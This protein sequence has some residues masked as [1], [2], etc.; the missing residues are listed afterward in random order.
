MSQPKVRFPGSGVFF[1]ELKTRVAA[2]L[3][4]S[5]KG[6][7]GTAEMHWKTAII[8]MWLGASYLGLLLWAHT[9]PQIVALAASLGLAMAGIGF[10]IQHD[11]NHGGYSG[12]S[13]VNRVMALTLDMVGGSSYVWHWKHNVIH[14]TY[15]NIPQV[16]ADT[17][18][19]FFARLT[20]SHV[21]RGFHRYQH[22]YVWGLYALLPF[23][24]VFVDDFV[25]LATG[26]IGTQHFPK[27]SRWGM[28]GILA[29]KVFYVSW[30]LVLPLYLHPVAGVA[31]AYVVAALI[32]GLTLAI[33]FQVAH[34]QAD[35]EFPLPN[36]EGAM[37][38]DWATHQVATTVDFARDSRVL[39][40][41]LGGLNFQVEH[42]LFPRVCH[43]HYPAI[44]RIVEATCHD[45]GIRY[46]TH[47]TFGQ[48]LLAHARWLREMGSAPVLATTAP[49][50]A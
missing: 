20:P 2:H 40:W 28:A 21:R 7:H 24:W 49:A 8:L 42:H 34:C 46:R 19:G 16:D 39:T 6:D 11:G 3:A 43:V 15:S 29:M 12:R 1:S 41:L 33:V 5:G 23:K 38:T 30:A 44:S 4:A 27:P 14:H 37:A 9:I 18:V 31:L 13:W 47:A 45:F 22:F 10:N 32:L 50:L 25:D 26:R 35:A 36:A 48:A 17:D